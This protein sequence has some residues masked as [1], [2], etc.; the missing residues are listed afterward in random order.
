MVQGTG[1]LSASSMEDVLQPPVLMSGKDWICPPHPT[2]SSQPSSLHEE[3]TS[4]VCAEGLFRET[5][6]RRK[7][8]REERL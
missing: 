6:E 5:G 1:L 8:E 7:R 3:P 4:L 2:T